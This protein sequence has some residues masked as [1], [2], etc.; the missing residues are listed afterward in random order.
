M[1]WGDSGHY[2]GPKVGIEYGAQGCGVTLGLL[3]LE[4]FSLVPPLA[5]V[6]QSVAAPPLVSVALDLLGPSLGLSG[7]FL[8]L[9]GPS[10][11]L[12]SS[13]ASQPRNSCASV[14]MVLTGCPVMC[15]G[16]SRS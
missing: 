8:G 6:P 5:L 4:L 12:P 15:L 9:R 2:K 16:S 1:D 13:L 10:L 14:W 11:L 3:G 7:L